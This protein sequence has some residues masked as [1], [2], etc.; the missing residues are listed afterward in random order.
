[1]SSLQL[2]SP[3]RGRDTE[4]ARLGEQLAHLRSGRGAIV[5]IDGAPGM[6]KS[7]LLGEAAAPARRLGAR[8]SRQ[9]S[10]IGKD[11]V[12]LGGLMDALLG[13]TGPLVAAADLSD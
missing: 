8:V 13:G 12:P 5:V 9:G 3:I 1:M 6:G 7:R 11:V 4:V 10:S 2:R